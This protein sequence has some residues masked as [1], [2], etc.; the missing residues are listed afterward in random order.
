VITAQRDLD[1]AQQALIDTRLSRA[2][3]LVELD[4]ALGGG[5]T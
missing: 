2:T 1:V 4:R 3:N 5:W